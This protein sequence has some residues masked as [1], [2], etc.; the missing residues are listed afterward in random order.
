MRI[1]QIL[2]L[3]L[4]LAKAEFKLKNENSYIGIFW[5][6]LNPLLTFLLL[7]AVF[8]NRLGNDI[9]NYPLYL[10]LGIII[11]NIFQQAT[12]EATS[13]IY[14]YSGQIKSIK[15]PIESFIVSINLK[16][17][18]SHI[19]EI[20]MLIVFLIF[21]KISV[22]GMIFYPLIF[23]FLAIFTIGVSLILSSLTVFLRDLVNIWAFASR[24]LWLATPIF[25][26]VGGQTKL[27]VFN[28]FNPLYYFISVA[29]DLIV[30]FRIPPLWMVTGMMGYSLLSLIVGL[31]VFNMLKKE[32]AELI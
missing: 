6:L 2:G 30:Y 13:V 8:S 3:S 32:F 4:A 11:F 18:F 15:M 29:R 1:K 16:N 7:L 17:L 28:L 23:F 31:M 12:T 19:F 25:Y 22:M 5:Y 10:L 27:L 14:G 20:T 26:A 9:P 24:L 21:F